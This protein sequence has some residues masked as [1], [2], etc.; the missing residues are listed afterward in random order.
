[1]TNKAS[2]SGFDLVSARSL[3][4]AMGVLTF[5]TWLY[6]NLASLQWLFDSLINRLVGK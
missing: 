5:A 6:A 4:M 2:A 1:M 3:F